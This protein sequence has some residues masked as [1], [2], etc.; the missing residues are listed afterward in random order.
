MI[1]YDTRMGLDAIQVNDDLVDK[2]VKTYELLA[3]NNQPNTYK[4][5]SDKKE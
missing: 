1:Q 5:I 4:W 2:M 3:S